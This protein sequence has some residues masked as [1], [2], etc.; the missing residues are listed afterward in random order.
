LIRQLFHIRQQGSVAEYVEQF[1]V[2]VVHLSTYEANADP[3]Y[4]TPV[5]V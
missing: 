4:Y 1:S 5:D 2:L 3:L